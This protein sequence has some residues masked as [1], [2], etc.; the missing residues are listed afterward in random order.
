MNFFLWVDGAEHGPY[1]VETLRTAILSGDTSPK[2]L[3]RQ[4]SG[5]EW[6]PLDTILPAQSRATSP[7]RPINLRAAAVGL[8]AL[9]CVAAAWKGLTAFSTQAQAKAALQK[10]VAAEAQRKKAIAATLAEAVTLLKK[11]E[12]ATVA[13]LKLQ[14]YSVRVVDTKVALDAVMER[15]PAGE[16]HRD[17]LSAIMATFLDAREFWSW[18]NREYSWVIN[19]PES[20]WDKYK[21]YGVKIASNGNSGTENIRVIWQAASSALSELDSEVKSSAA[22]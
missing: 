2:T 21:A 19:V 10:E 17:A 1:D 11:L 8:A 20:A 5:K 15:L 12:S 22:P 9:L 4:D 14:E 18:T 7:P 13:G 6:K 16:P 3:A